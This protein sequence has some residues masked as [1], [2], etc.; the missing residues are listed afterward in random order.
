MTHTHKWYQRRLTKYFED[1]YAFA[2][3]DAGFYPDPADNQW[4]FMLPGSGVLIEL[5]CQDDGIVVENRYAKGGAT[6]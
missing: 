1:H 4:L 5:T 6:L 3:D 2:E